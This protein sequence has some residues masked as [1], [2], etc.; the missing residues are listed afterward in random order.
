MT[1]ELPDLY[2]IHQSHCQTSAIS[3]IDGKTTVNLASFISRCRIHGRGP[4][5]WHY[6]SIPGRVQQYKLVAGCLA[7]LAFS[8]RFLQMLSQ[9]RRILAKRLPR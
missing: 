1:D 5:S 2:R 4:K 8:Q 9:S 3:T 6:P 7:Y